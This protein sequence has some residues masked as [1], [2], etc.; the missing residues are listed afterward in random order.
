MKKVTMLLLLAVLCTVGAKSQNTWTLL[1]YLPDST[2]GYAISFQIGDKFYVG[3]GSSKHGH[4]DS[5]I[6]QYNVPTNTWTKKSDFPGGNR[7]LSIGFSLNGL[8]Y[9][10]S[11]TDFVSSYKD[12]YEYNPATDVWTYKGVS[13]KTFAGVL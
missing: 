1:N 5:S 10:M 2:R 4:S 6:W 3:L 11:G 8:G 7:N 12:V 9:V 13:P